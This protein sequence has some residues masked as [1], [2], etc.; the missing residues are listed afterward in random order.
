[1]SSQ[2]TDS[3]WLG[4][5][6]STETA[7]WSWIESS[8]FVFTNWLNS[9]FQSS[10]RCAVLIRQYNSR[11]VMTD[12]N[13]DQNEIRYNYIC[14]KQNLVDPAPT[15]TPLVTQP[16]VNYGCEQGWSDFESSCYKLSNALADH[17]SFE[18]AKSVCKQSGADLV[19]IFSER[20][21]QFLVSMLR[22]R[23]SSSSMSL[24]QSKRYGCPSGWFL[25]YDSCYQFVANATKSWNFGQNYCRRLGGNL[26]TI[27]SQNEQ[28]FVAS[29]IEQCNFP[30]FCF[31]YLHCENYENII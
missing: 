13:D 19:E 7:G 5:Y 18:S 1:M 31:L 23:L 30:T 3:F 24:A 4:A 12:C 9:G 8:P 27:R 22:T 25:V 11:W 20:E 17:V 14:K 21:N 6:R 29:I 26:V 2:S 16:G 28:S 10:K 15:T